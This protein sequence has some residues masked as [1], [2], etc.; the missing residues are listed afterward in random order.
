MTVLCRGSTEKALGRR[1][2]HMSGESEVA[3]RVC[4]K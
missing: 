4:E 2:K 1:L 3:A